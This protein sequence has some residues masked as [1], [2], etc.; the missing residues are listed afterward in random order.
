MPTKTSND[1]DNRIQDDYD[2]KFDNIAENSSTAELSAADLDKLENYAN[3][4]GEERGDGKEPANAAEKTRQQEDEVGS[5]WKTDIKGNGES[6]AKKER[7]IWYL[8]NKLVKKRGPMTVIIGLILGGFGGMSFIF[9][10]GMLIVHFKEIMNEKF[11]DQLAAMD[12]RTTALIKKKFGKTTD[13]FCGKK[14]TIRCRYN[15]MS[16]R[17]VKKLEKAGIKVNTGKSRIPKRVKIE[18]FEFEGKVIRADNFARELRADPSFRGAMMKGYNP[19]LA[20]FA[21]NLF[22]KLAD[23]LGIKKQKNLDS[24][25]AKD[26]LKSSKK[27]STKENLEE[28]LDEQVRDTVSG[29]A[30]VEAK[31]GVSKETEDCNGGDG[32][33]D[34]KKTVYKDENGATITEDQYNQRVNAAGTLESELETRRSLAKTGKKITKATLKGALLSTALGLG[35]VDSACT[36]YVLIRYVGYAAKAIAARQLLRFAHMINNEG[37]AVKAL[38]GAPI[39]TEYLGDKLTKPNAV[40][41]TATDSYGYRY[42]AYGDAGAM[43]RG[44]NLEATSVGQNGNN[45]QLDEKNKQKA[46]LDDEVTKYIN[47][48]LVSNSLL[49][50][51]IKFTGKGS[52]VKGVDEGCKFIKSGVGQTIVIGTALVGA[53]VAFFSGGASLGWG[54]AAQ[55][56]VSV[57]LSV[58]FAMLLPKLVDMASGTLITGKENGNQIGNAATSGNGAYNAQTA[59]ARGLPALKKED[60]IAYG[61]LTAEVAAQYDAVEREER[62]PFDPTSS[63]TFVG[64]IVSRLIPYS[65]KLTSTTSFIPAASQ[66][67]ASSF[68]NLIPHSSASFRAEEFEVCQDRD[69]KDLNLAADPFCNLR[70]GLSKADLEIDPDTVLTY[71]VEN[72]YAD[73]FTGEPTSGDNEYAK[74]IEYCIDRNAPVGGYVSE[75]DLN[76]GH[77][78]IKGQNSGE[79]ERMY[80]MFRLFYIDQSIADGMTNGYATVG[81]GTTGAQAA[82]GEWVNPAGDKKYQKSSKFGPRTLNGVSRLHEGLDMVFAGDFVAACSGRITSVGR[83]GDWSGRGP[84]NIITID[85]GDGIVTR[86]MHYYTR[87]IASGVKEGAE[88]KAGTKLAK[89][90]NQ[91]HSF[92]AH[93]HFEVRQKGKAIDPV[94]FMKKVGVEL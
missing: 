6:N 91:G 74:Y 3:T 2:K 7:E 13:G 45:I 57:S 87:T 20:G 22:A 55:V 50:A 69:Y 67:V 65:S 42:A 76:E 79:K 68:S 58:A 16:N 9:S 18:S 94:P 43:S 27:P 39:D 25:K 29:D 59:Q 84:T 60:A 80:T 86:Y 26:K 11:N 37:D 77:E 71:M 32:C 90:G 51:I 61:N 14:V 23:K 30:A 63:K 52:D 17:Q 19:K 21:D 92:G 46:E 49:A 82:S 53:V 12:L 15:T 56:G 4:G 47:G 35:A 93:L 83:L 62:G 88:V 28:A 1:Q 40:G 44:D 73:E 34:G 5:S 70:Y 66:L 64:S 33:E 75:T 89:V 81:G 54:T 36:G 10:P 31:A 24:E 41:N 85:C 72:N 38:A 48:Q 78:C 8:T